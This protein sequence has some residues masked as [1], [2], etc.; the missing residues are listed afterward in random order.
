MRQK[1]ELKRA[2][3][4]AELY[5]VY[6]NNGGK[7]TYVYPK[8]HAIK[9]QE[10]ETVYVFTLRNGMD[11]KEVKKK[12][13]VFEQFFGSKLELEGD[14]KRFTIKVYKKELNSFYDYK[15]S[16]F[17]GAMLECN[18]PIIAGKD[19]L[20][21]TVVFD[22]VENPMLLIAGETGGGK[23]SSLRG[24]ITSLIQHKSNIKNGL[25]L[26]LT[27]FKRSEFHL[28]R[29]LEDTFIINQKRDFERCIN[30]LRYEIDKRGDLLDSYELSHIDQYN[31][32]KNIDVKSYIILVID[33]VHVLEGDDETFE[34]IHTVSAMGRALGI[35]IILA[36]QRPDAQVIDGKTKAN[37][38]VRYAFAHA[39]KINSDITLGRGVK[40]DASKITRPGQFIYRNKQAFKNYDML[41]SPRLELD[42]AKKLVEPFKIPLEKR[43]KTN[44]S[45]VINME[46]SEVEE[47][48]QEEELLEEQILGVLDR[49]TNTEG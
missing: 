47:G 4:K 21:K 27:D 28:F 23:S 29:Y 22:M 16:D 15:Y 26:Y 3:H 36:T 2:F 19:R 13:F 49:G 33:E 12:Q 24:I 11:P 25:T 10:Y 41:Q 40:A 48:L 42:A 5:H 46:H 20:G 32:L 44:Q 31:G 39:D 6:K 35:Y 38:T 1:A 7:A 9:S 8:I 45:D 14:V 30:N 18:L 37:L 34:K 43:T 17:K